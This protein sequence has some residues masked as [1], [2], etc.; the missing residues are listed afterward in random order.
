MWVLKR[1]KDVD[2]KSSTISLG[3]ADNDAQ[4]GLAA[5]CGKNALEAEK[6][7][8]KSIKLSETPNSDELQTL[9]YKE[10]V[11]IPYCHGWHK[12]CIMECVL[13]IW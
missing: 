9:F 11:M 7:R 12:S 1:G 3:W 5:C 13:Y 10:G 4:D 2:F 6:S 8:F